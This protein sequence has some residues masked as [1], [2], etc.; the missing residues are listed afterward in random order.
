MILW[1]AEYAARAT[2]VLIG[3]IWL[4]AT[5]FSLAVLHRRGPQCFARDA[6]FED[7]ITRISDGNR[8]RIVGALLSSALS[9]AA[10]MALLG[11]DRVNMGLITAKLALWCV[12]LGVL[13]TVSWRLWPA[14]VF[15]LPHELP[16]LRDVQTRLRVLMVGALG[17]SALLGLLAH[18]LRDAS[19]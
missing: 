18:A 3:T 1:F 8:R 11:A 2:H 15:A 16:R 7:F 13:Y 17:M 9:G 4:G 12:S 6:D 14:R 5:W 10:L 19:H